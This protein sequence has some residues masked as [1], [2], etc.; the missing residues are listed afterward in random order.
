MGRR[1]LVRGRRTASRQRDV[2]VLHYVH[3]L[4]VTE[5]ALIVRAPEGTVKSELSRARGR[6]RAR[7]VGKEL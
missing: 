7:L 4:A 2:T 3:D 6:L 5:I 1:V